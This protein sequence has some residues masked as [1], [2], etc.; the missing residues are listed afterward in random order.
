MQAL[1]AYG[2]RGF[3][4]RKPHFLQSVPYAIKNL[5]WLLQNA[6]LPIAL[7]ALTSAFQGIVDSQKLLALVAEGDRR[8]RAA[9]DKPQHF[10][11]LPRQINLSRE[12]LVSLS[13][14]A[15]RPKTRPATAE[16]LFSM[17][18]ACPIPDAKSDSRCSPAKTLP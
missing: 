9:P 7:P 10:C 1:G 14:A 5:R 11:P 13:I 17:R 2:F 4:E 12:F 8:G 3:Y 16:D 6:T 15:A 18:A